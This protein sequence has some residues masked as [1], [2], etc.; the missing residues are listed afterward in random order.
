M[1]TVRERIAATGQAVPSPVVTFGFSVLAFAVAAAAVRW[2]N[3]RRYRVFSTGEAPATGAALGTT[4]LK[5]AP[6]S[7]RR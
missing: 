2:A 5:K 1:L 6:L 3:R 7:G 4:S